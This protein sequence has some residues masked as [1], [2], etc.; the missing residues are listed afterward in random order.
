MEVC[1][2]QSNVCQPGCPVWFYD[3]LLETIFLEIKPTCQPSR[4]LNTTVYFAFGRSTSWCYANFSNKL[5]C[6]LLTQ[7]SF[8]P[9]TVPICSALLHKS[10]RWSSFFPFKSLR[11]ACVFCLAFKNNPSFPTLMSGSKCMLGSKM[12][13]YSAFQGWSLLLLLF[14]SPSPFYLSFVSL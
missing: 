4:I 10:A 7:E 5:R 2:G 11:K 14:R 3:R 13:P 12:I 1:G 6:C 8:L 9:P